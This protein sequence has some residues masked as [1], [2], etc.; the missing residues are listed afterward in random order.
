MLMLADKA[1]ISDTM[2]M[3]KVITTYEPISSM[4]QP[5]LE[6]FNLLVN[7]TIADLE[8][9]AAD[10]DLVALEKQRLA[11]EQQLGRRVSSLI[12]GCTGDCWLRPVIKLADRHAGG[13][14]S[15]KLF[16]LPN[17]PMSRPPLVEQEE[18]CAYAHT[19]ARKE[20]ERFISPE[21]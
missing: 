16:C 8:E 7:Q 19:V 3:V 15:L 12:E 20:F 6:G 18:N 21:A 17:A 5:A 13:G 2:A 10:D 1:V 11:V 4:G 9:Q 14:P